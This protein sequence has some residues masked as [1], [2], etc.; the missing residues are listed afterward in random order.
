[1]AAMSKAER[2]ALAALL[3]IFTWFTW[4]GAA[5]FFSGDDMMNMYG[6]WTL[7]ASRLGR[8]LIEIWIPVYRPLGA[9]VYRVFYA[10][11]GFHPLP[12]YILCWLLLAA[13]VV[14][15]WRFLR[16]VLPKPFA[17]LTALSIVLVHGTFQ[18]LYISAGTIYDRL[19]F[20][21]IVL[22]L[23]IYARMKEKPGV[24]DSALVCLMC[25]LA[26]DSKE[27]GIALPVLLAIYEVVFVRRSFRSV[28]PLY[29]ALTAISLIFVFL[30][31]HRTPALTA[32]AAYAP[33]ASPTLWLTRIAEYFG[34]LTYGH[35]SF[36]AVTVAA[37]LVVTAAIAVFLRDRAMI[38]GWLFFAVTVTP[39][40]LIASRPG[41][42]LY[43]PE[44]GLGIWFAGLL[45]RVGAERLPV[46]AFAVVTVATLWFHA[47]N[48]PAPLSPADSPEFRL[49]E[50]FRRE[51]PDLPKGA[52]LLFVSDAFP[53]PAFDLLFNLRMMYH[54]PTIR[55]DR[56]EAP[57]DQQPD[58]KNPVTY[59]RVF[60][61]ESGRYLELDPRDPGESQRLHILKDYTV[62]REL[63]IS[64]RDHAAYIVS[65]VMDGEGNDPSRW[66]TPQAK[67]K[68]DL[69]PAP[70]SFSAKFW[71]P[72]FVAKTASRTLHILIDGK[73]L[74]DYPLNHDGMNEPSFKVP[75]ELI[76]RNGYTIVDLNVENP[77]KDPAG[78]AF[79]VVLLRA[80]F[81]Y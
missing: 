16:E 19:S 24:G 25:I 33:H 40:A 37:V 22:G 8:S 38:F 59:D 65:G 52:K 34:I 30:R 23:T 70:A 78:T 10:I 51:Y 15:A 5:M 13:N 29:A 7:N 6:A 76:T 49:T 55:A 69:Y 48:W 31:V 47:R 79:G 12:L 68:F 4:R 80:G 75:P 35:V 60:V 50:Q 14:L 43:V 26:M 2:A 66:T 27:S 77:Y 45:W 18:D 42:V 56:L 61:W 57:P 71:V 53:K 39:V 64:R 46:A 73:P 20:L 21:F 44:L 11:F 36:T 72:D 1:M 63:D 28:A 32:N 62:G 81:V 17:A 3:A 41:Y 74:A 67:L 58:R 9:A 54:D